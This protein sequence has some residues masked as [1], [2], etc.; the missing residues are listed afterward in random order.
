ML[1][2]SEHIK[3]MLIADADVDTDAYPIYVGAEPSKP[4]DC[5][6]L[7]DYGAGEQLTLDLTPS[8]S[9]P[10]VQGRVRATSYLDGWAFIESVKKSLHGRA[11]EPWDGMFYALIQCLNGPM[12]MDL[13]ENQRVRF[14][15]NFDIQRYP[16]IT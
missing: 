12:F 16:C 2:S 6:T 1:P 8:Y 7:F 13:D 3:Q 15:I 14:V 9:L 5:F 10:S 11:N 4:N